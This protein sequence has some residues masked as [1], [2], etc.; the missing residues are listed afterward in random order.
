MNATFRA[1]FARVSAAA[2]FAFF[3][4]LTTKAEADVVPEPD[5][6]L[7][8]TSALVIVA[9]IVVLGAVALGIVRRQKQN[10]E[11]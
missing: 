1:R 8:G 4:L 6:S 11:T 3:V 7:T 10:S 2:A 9:G 5:S